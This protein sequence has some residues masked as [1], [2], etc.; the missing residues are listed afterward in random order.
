MFSARTWI[1]R[2]I[3]VTATVVAA[4]LVWRSV[5]SRTVALAA[6]YHSDLFDST[7]TFR[8]VVLVYIGDATC[9]ACGD[10]KF[11]SALARLTKGLNDEAKRRG[12][13]FH[14]IGVI[15]TPDKRA[16]WKYLQEHGDWDEVSIGGGWGNSFVVTHIWDRA[17]DGAVPKVL[18]FTRDVTSRNKMLLFSNTGRDREFT[19]SSTIENIVQR[20]DWEHL[21]PQASGSRVRR[22]SSG[23]RE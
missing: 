6:P 23:T 19:G 8:Q 11:T 20:G 18:I 15:V 7:G 17:A 5:E 12:M 13:R 10:P 14:S 3:L 4:L 9:H 16:G 22:S 21:I 1:D 2:L